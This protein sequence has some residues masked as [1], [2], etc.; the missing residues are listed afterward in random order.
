MTHIYSPWLGAAESMR[1]VVN[2][3]VAMDSAHPPAAF[4]P[5]TAVFGGIHPIVAL[6]KQLLNMME[7]LV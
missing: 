2:G 7:T 4:S 6:G 3:Q 1:V 5:L